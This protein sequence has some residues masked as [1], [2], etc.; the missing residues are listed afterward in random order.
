MPRERVGLAMGSGGWKGLAHLGV[1]RALE[2]LEIRPAVYA[3]AS[4]G[5]LVAAAAASRTRLD[6]LEHVAARC[7]REPLFR[8]DLGGLLRHGIRTPALFRDTPLR[9]LCRELF[10]ETTFA[11]LPTPALVATLDLSTG[12]T[13][14]WGT[15]R[16]RHTSIADAVYASCA[17]PGLL[18]PGRVDARLCIDG[19]VL[20][21]LGLQGLRNQVDRIIVVEL[22]TVRG[23]A[24]PLSRPRASSLWWTAQSLVIRD[25][26][27]HQLREWDGPPVQVIRPALRGVEILTVADPGRVIRAGYDAALSGLRDQDDEPVEVMDC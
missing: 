9:S 2:E 18:P 12:E 10:G 20:D 19:G 1:L 23:G 11:D 16:R 3:G 4:A 6:H 27:R 14:W 13:V 26:T 5:A 7:R 15:E 25:L 24:D 22:G 17:L 8:L 21:P